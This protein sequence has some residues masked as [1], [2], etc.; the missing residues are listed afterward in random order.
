M[1]QTFEEHAGYMLIWAANTA[2]IIDLRQ[3]FAMK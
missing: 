3:L 1:Q 2:E